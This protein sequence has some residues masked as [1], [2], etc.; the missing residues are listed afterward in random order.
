MHHIRSHARTHTRTPVHVPTHIVFYKCDAS[1]AIISGV[2]QRLPNLW[3]GDYKFPGKRA[4][5]SALRPFRYW[6]TCAGLG[7]CRLV[8]SRRCA[9]ATA[10]L[11]VAIM[12]HL[13]VLASPVPVVYEIR[14]WHMGVRVCVRF[15]A[16]DERG[17]PNG[18][19]E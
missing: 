2:A 4:P 12:R 10:Y 6:V 18:R 3:D 14:F 15:G 11:A 17:P 8:G 1:G 16:S 5:R 9:A 13:V 7:N 19:I